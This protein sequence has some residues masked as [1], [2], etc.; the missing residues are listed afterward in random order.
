M[1]VSVSSAVRSGADSASP[2]NFVA[3]CGRAPSTP[4]SIDTERGQIHADMAVD[5]VQR[6]SSSI[7]HR[8]GRT[9]RFR[10]PCCASLRLIPIQGRCPAGPRH[11]AADL[12]TAAAC[13]YRAR[14]TSARRRRGPCAAAG[15]HK[16]ERGKQDR[17]LNMAANHFATTLSSTPP[18]PPAFGTTTILL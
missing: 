3:R 18:V 5:A 12:H 2:L 13:G 8:R 15:N 4:P 9:A 10:S 11:T 6:P 16:A 14:H 1:R 7:R 17:M